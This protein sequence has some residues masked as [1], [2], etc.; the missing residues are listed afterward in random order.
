MIK[1]ELLLKRTQQMNRFKK[2]KHSEESDHK[3]F[4]DTEKISSKEL[5]SK[6]ERIALGLP[7]NTYKSFNIEVEIMH[8]DV[9][10]EKAI[11]QLADYESD[12]ND[13]K[14]STKTD[15]Q[16]PSSELATT[17]KSSTKNQQKIVNRLQKNID[18][19]RQMLGNLEDK[20]TRLHILLEEQKKGKILKNQLNIHRNR[21]FGLSIISIIASVAIAI[22][23]SIAN[24]SR[25]IIIKHI[26]DDAP[27]KN[28]F[29]VE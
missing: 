5:K 29:S 18:E 25:E 8:L 20:R 21:M 13:R 17:T 10:I 14:N 11:N 22:G 24:N 9:R 26:P 3:Y 4:T 1:L 15:Y 2:L 16:L 7:P 12:L 28:S 6:E 23:S 27:S 19:H